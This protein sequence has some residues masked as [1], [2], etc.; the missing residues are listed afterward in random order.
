MCVQMFSEREAEL[1]QGWTVS[2]GNTEIPNVCWAP[3]LRNL[4][5]AAAKQMKTKPGKLGQSLTCLSPAPLQAQDK[6]CGLF[7]SAGVL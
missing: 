7:L 2:K 4:G 5:A 1:E 3:R 6:T